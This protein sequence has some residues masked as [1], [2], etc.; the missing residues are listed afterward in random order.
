MCGLKNEFALGF[1][2][3]WL[4]PIAT[5]LIGTKR[6]PM[7]SVDGIAIYVQH[8]IEKLK[9]IQSGSSHTRETGLNG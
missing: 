9:L 3:R 5:G 2:N 6:G 1:E 4:E 8:A 7:Y